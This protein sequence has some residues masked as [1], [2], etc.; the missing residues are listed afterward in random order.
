MYFELLKRDEEVSALIL[1][2]NECMSARGYTE[3]GLRHTGWVAEMASR[4]LDKLG[5]SQADMDLVKCAGLLHDIGNSLTRQNHGAYSA[6]LAY[7]ILLRIGMPYVDAVKVTS[8]IA[9]HEEQSGHPV[10][11]LASALVIADKS[12]VNRTRVDFSKKFDS[13]D[14]H[15]R[16]N[17]AVRDNTIDIDTEARIINSRFTMEESAS[18]MDFLEI[19]ADRMEMCEN[20]ASILNATFHL[21]INGSKIN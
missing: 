6:I 8:A 21:Y 15:D 7:P 9:N 16:V 3:H 19:Y 20:A 18:V 10:N 12:D 2:A 14:I 11:I 13:S 5:Y 17:F 1:G 4:I